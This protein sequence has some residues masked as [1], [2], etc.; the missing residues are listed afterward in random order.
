MLLRKYSSLSVRLTMVAAMMI[1]GSS[2]LSAQILTVAVGKAYQFHMKTSKQSNVNIPAPF[3]NNVSPPSFAQF[4]GDNDPMIYTVGVDLPVGRTCVFLEGT[5]EKSSMRNIFSGSE[6]ILGRT[7]SLSSNVYSVGV[8]HPVNGS[9][10]VRLYSLL[11]IAVKNYDGVNT[12]AGAEFRYAYNTAEALRIGCGVM[13]GE[14]FGI[15]LSIKTGA[16]FESGGIERAEV[17]VYENG[18]Q[19][20]RL[21]PEGDRMLSDHIVTLSVS[22]KYGIDLGLISP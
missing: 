4:F 11:G 9:G 6:N 2:L 16:T 17:R 21:L 1:V 20:A 12:I 10:N 3:Q 18:V 8:S 14:L 5:F 22:L 19:K 13:F 15:P 7:L